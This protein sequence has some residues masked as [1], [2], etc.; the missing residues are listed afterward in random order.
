M[1]FLLTK[2]ASPFFRWL[3][4][5]LALLIPFLIITW[6]YFQRGLS[7]DTSEITYVIFAIFIFGFLSS[8][9]NSARIS[10]ES[11]E[12]KQIAKNRSVDANKDGV[13][14]L[15]KQ[16]KVAIDQGDQIDFSILLTAY[17]AKMAGRVRGVGTTAGILITVG[18][19][20]TVI[21]LILT[22]NGIS[23][24]LG[25]AGEDY[26]AMIGGLNDTV[27][28]MGTAFYT[29]FF[30]GLLGGVIL[31]ALA[32]EN[33]K[34]ANRLTADC[35][36]LGELWIMP[37]SRTLASK[38]AG[39]LQTEVLGLM[40]ILRDLGDGIAKTSEVIEQNKII[41]DRQFANLVSEAKAE[42]SQ[43]LQIG[44]SEMVT[45]F[46]S[47]VSTIESGHQP[48]K[49]KM[50]ELSD[51]IGSAASATSDAVEETKNVQNKILDGRALELANKLSAAAGLIEE[52][53]DESED[54][55]DSDNDIND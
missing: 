19:L 41:M 35:L 34:T 13:H 42:M 44:L 31:K 12:L 4:L 15:F 48:I 53:I 27:Q 45:G 43:S 5:C 26:S 47:I 9:F 11:Y 3:I 36:E 28:G 51:A 46:E 37:M 33:E 50:T 22:I 39:N 29:T 2:K 20:G 23:S 16:A 7:S 40:N 6:E 38:I 1:N 8:V 10:K 14:G 17:S 25:A 32:A 52:F 30:G 21:G 18:L 49:D 55:L 24:V 54:E